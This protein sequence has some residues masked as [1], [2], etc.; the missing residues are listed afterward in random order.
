MSWKKRRLGDEAFTE[1]RN[2]DPEAVRAAMAMDASSR[3]GD[4]FRECGGGGAGGGEAA[5]GGGGGAVG[6]DPGPG[7]G[8]RD[9]DA[10]AAPRKEK[11]WSSA[12]AAC[13]LSGHPPSPKAEAAVAARAAE[14]AGGE[15]GHDRRGCSGGGSG[16]GG[17][18][19]YVSGAAHMVAGST[20]RNGT[21]GG[22]T[23][24]DAAHAGQGVAAAAAAAATAAVPASAPAPAE[25]ERK[26][27][28][29]KS[30]W[31]R[32]GAAPTRKT[33]WR[34]LIDPPKGGESAGTRNAGGGT[35]SS[36]WNRGP[37]AA[38]GVEGGAQGGVSAGDDE[39]RAPERVSGVRRE[40]QQRRAFRFCFLDR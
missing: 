35:R 21:D 28:R 2:A 25:K 38:A 29:P 39:R 13:V 34:Q 37:A 36:R 23:G 1:G 40:N 30:V 17:I 19:S 7:G 27:P 6:G 12:A 18:F 26:A 10:D 14:M 15:R 16:G 24:A 32:G 9:G 8:G 4:Q 11:H 3:R 5:G 20:A 33:V 22:F 31:E